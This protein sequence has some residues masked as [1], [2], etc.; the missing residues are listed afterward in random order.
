M[1]HTVLTTLF[2]HSTLSGKCGY[3]LE[4]SAHVHGPKNLRTDLAHSSF[5]LRVPLKVPL[6]VPHRS[7]GDIYPQSHSTAT[8]SLIHAGEESGTHL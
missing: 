7:T 6:Q 5:P 8:I 4:S 1:G 2:N 3:H